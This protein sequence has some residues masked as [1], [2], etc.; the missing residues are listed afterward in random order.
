MTKTCEF[1]RLP[2]NVVP[3]H[4]NLE[5]QPDLTA[6]T[7]Q[8]KTAVKIQVSS[9]CVRGALFGLISYV[10]FYGIAKNSQRTPDIACSV[11]HTEQ[12][13]VRLHYDVFS[14]SLQNRYILLHVYVCR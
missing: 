7:F 8:G 3:V 13:L 4:Y 1:E 11:W 14:Y 6:F 2:K 5:L 10:A 9:V 12:P